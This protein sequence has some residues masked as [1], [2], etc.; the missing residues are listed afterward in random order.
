MQAPASGE[1]LRVEV[2]SLGER[3]SALRLCEPSALETVR[4]SL[5]QH[6]QLSALTLFREGTELEIVDGFKRVRAARELGLQT[7]QGRI[8]TL[9]AV[10]AKLRLRALQQC[11]GLT[12]LEEGWLVRS[13]Y[14]EDGRTLPEIARLMQRHKTWVWRRLMLVEALTPALQAEVRLG[15]V[16]PRAAVLVGR[17]PHGNQPA[18]SAV[19]MRR[20]LT[21]RQ[22]ELL[23]AEALAEQ[24][25]CARAALLVQRLDEIAPSHTP[26]PRPVRHVR[27]ESEWMSADILKLHEVAAR[28]TARLYATP[29]D[30]FAS[31]SSQLLRD[32]LVRLSPV[33][34]ALDAVVETV[35]AHRDVA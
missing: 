21:V 16:A 28:L 18:A 8:D 6:G 17:L 19:V 7:L 15:L 12:E 3:L 1:V 2:G 10:E 5:E 32:A 22:T 34:R 4:R 26:G 14:R 33:L 35:A 9:D 29:L 23:V 31:G 25:P 20:G 11:S 24:D 30:T 27:S 13:L